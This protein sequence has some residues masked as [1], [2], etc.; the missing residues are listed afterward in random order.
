MRIKTIVLLIATTF[1]ILVLLQNREEASFWLLGNRSVSKSLVIGGS[2][3]FG[4]LFG[5]LIAAKRKAAGRQL[6]DED[7]RFIDME[8][9][10]EQDDED[11]ENGLSDDDRD[12]I[13]L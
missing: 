6:S 11:D 3:A 7:R 9:T 2:L 12:Y 4:M 10:E 5:L 1:A 8:D 13:R